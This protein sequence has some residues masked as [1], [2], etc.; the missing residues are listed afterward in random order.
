MSQINRNVVVS[1]KISIIS[2]INVLK[3]LTGS[4]LSIQDSIHGFNP[5]SSLGNEI[6][7]PF[8][9]L[10]KKPYRGRDT[11]NS[12]QRLRYFSLLLLFVI[13]AAIPSWAQEKDLW[14]TKTVDKSAVTRG[15]IVNYTINYGNRTPVHDVRIVDVLPKVDF[16]YASP[17]P[18]SIAG[19]NLTWNFA[20]LPPH[21]SGIIGR[22]TI[23]VQLPS[24]ANISFDES[25][26]VY[27]DGFVNVRKSLSTPKATLVNN[28]TIS[29]TLD[30]NGNN[31][32]DTA[33]AKVNIYGEQGEDI[34]S[35]E[36]GSGYY[37][38]K[39]TSILNTTL[40]S[41]GLYNKISAKRKPS[42][43][44]LLGNRTISYDSAWYDLI[45]VKNYN[46][47][48]SVSE[49]YQYM[50]SMNKESS[51]HAD[52]SQT[53]YS[54]RSNFSGGR[55]ETRY[56]IHDSNSKR[57]AMDI[58]E[59]YHGNFTTAQ[60]L[61][62]Y[63]S[64]ASY[65]KYA[66]GIGYVSS[67]KRV[68]CNQRS[69]EHGSGSYESE[70]IISTGNIHKNSYMTYEPSN[71]SVGGVKI[72]YK[73]KFSD[74][75]YTRNPDQNSE[76]LELISTADNI[77]KETLI[78]PSFLG[79]TGRFNGTENLRAR[80][81]NSDIRRKN[82]SAE[83]ERFLIGNYRLDTT[84]V[85]SGI[86][87][88][89]GPHLNITKRVVSNDG[90]YIRY[91][92]NVSNDGNKTLAPVEVVDVLPDG[93]S[94]YSSSLRPTV[95]GRIVSWSLLALTVGSMETIDLT[96]RLEFQSQYP[97]NRIK[98]VAQ[99]QNRTVLAEASAPEEVILPVP[100]YNVSINFS[101]GPWVPPPCFDLRL[102]V[103]DCEK[104]MDEYYN[105]PNITYDCPIT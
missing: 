82:D 6:R 15:G 81:L 83:V 41:I 44:H 24:A 48:D 97:V 20:S 88:Y 22:I 51:F 19:N 10:E 32:N 12:R 77:Q 90:A 39:E 72:N 67:D 95:Q 74:L 14:I 100:T 52:S 7:I 60:S 89:L 69:D 42:S 66:N 27:G 104:D 105:N 34:E 62:S 18:D 46:V 70:E 26:Y 68:G 57:N 37:R 8:A 102:N 75:M 47:N 79:T 50:N 99:Y 85:I 92:I 98:A 91:R 78:G 43:F 61:D 30:N 54:S 2:I 58:S 33:S 25:S 11:M 13:F 3:N 103:T 65:T 101:S 86:P 53:I 28:V 64:T 17:E 76:I 45:T 16:L 71:E 96:V 93:T 55:A 56:V 4:L 94:F 38:E 1:T 49:N 9:V 87:K 23:T 73:S 80:L 35:Q 5:G 21:S 84:I 29:G 40:H 59:V 36:H 31:V 63:G